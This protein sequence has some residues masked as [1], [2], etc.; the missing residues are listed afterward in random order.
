MRQIF[1]DDSLQRSFIPTGYARV[2]MLS[3]AE[4]AHILSHFRNLQ[5]DDRFAPTGRDGF[6][7]RYHCSFLDTNVS[8]KRETHQLIKGV[9]ISTDTRF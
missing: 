9:F 1:R 6:Q 8:Y 5:P 4:I 7:F 2:P 3:P